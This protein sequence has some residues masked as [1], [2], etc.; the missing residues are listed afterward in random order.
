MDLLA[1]PP[2][3]AVLDAAYRA[4]MGLTHLLEPLAGAGAAAAAVVLVTLAVRAALIPVGVAQAKGERTRARLAP[5]LA[6]LQRRHRDDHAAL[7]RA[8]LA[9]YAEEGTSPF[10]GCPPVLAQAPVVGIV[11]AVFVHPVIAGHGNDLLGHTLLGVPLGT[12]LVG[13][14]AGGTASVA[15][16]AVFAVL[17]AGIAAVGEL[18]RRAVAP[19]GALAVPAAGAGAANPLA[20]PGARRAL[21]ALQFLTAGVA[22]VVP[23]AA[24]LYLLVTVWWTYAQ[25]RVLR[26]RF[27]L[28]G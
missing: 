20:G 19:G 15:V 2:V 12:G 6:A 13:S 28:D 26:R 14:V 24:G 16:L 23:L 8:T 7:Q 21:G 25:R 27:P 18:T 3:A 5:R 22:C 10:A 11:Y 1:L 9:L 17:V 4:L